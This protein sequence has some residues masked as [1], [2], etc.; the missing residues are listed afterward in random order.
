MSSLG[1]LLAYDTAAKYIIVGC[2]IN[3]SLSSNILFEFALQ[4]F[5]TSP[6]LSLPHSPS[7]NNNND[8]TNTTNA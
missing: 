6:R 3:K 8:N 7:S 5:L 1:Q 2:D 4:C